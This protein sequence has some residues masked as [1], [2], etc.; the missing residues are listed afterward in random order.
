M[1]QR[2]ILKLAPERRLIMTLAL[3]QALDIL[4]MPQLELASWLLNEIEKNPLLELDSFHFKKKRFEG[5]FPSPITLHEHLMAQIRDHFPEKNERII[6]ERL[7]HHLD[8]R[9]FLSCIDSDEPILK[10]LQTF[11]PPGIFARTLQ[12]SLLLQLKAKGKDKSLAFALVNTCYEDLLHG[13]YGAIK[14]KLGSSD[15]GKAIA[16]LS[17]LS[18]RPAHAFKEE[19]LSLVIPDLQI[20]KIDGG[21]TLE[22]MEDD[23]PP[24]HIQTEYLEVDTESEEE[25][26]ALRFFKTQAKWIFRSLNRRRKLLREIGRMLICK[27]ALFLD[28]KGPLAPLPTKELAEKLHIHESTLSRALFGKYVSTPRGILPLR[29]LLSADPKAENARQMLEELI[30]NEDKKN[31]L[32]DE[33]LAAL[34]HEKG[35]QVAR[36]TI[37]KYRGQLKIGSTAQRRNSHS[38]F[39]IGMMEKDDCDNSHRCDCGKQ[40]KG[41][42]I[43]A[44]EIDQTPGQDRSQNSRKR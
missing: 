12:E 34:L 42:L 18:L 24:F 40:K 11:D 20:Q 30:S 22:L 33:Q 41:S 2:L 5:D 19:P 6:A 4:Q 7:L 15:L 38:P 29:S 31:P 27:Q 44:R 35:F 36:R 26:E 39:A 8:E 28:Q 9:G 23:L 1:D 14:K 21:W 37:A 25:K 13:R 32:T 16:D 10:I 3:R 17:R 43:I